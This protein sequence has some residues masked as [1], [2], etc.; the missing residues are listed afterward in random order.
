MRIVNRILSLPFIMIIFF[1]TAMTLYVKWVYRYIL[2][3]GEF[4]P[5]KSKNDPKTIADLYRQLN[6]LLTNKQQPDDK[7]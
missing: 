7:S 1:I 2:F 4:I 6:R 5:Y 3:G